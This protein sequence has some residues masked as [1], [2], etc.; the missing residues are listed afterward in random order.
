MIEFNGELSEKC[1][2]YI[3]KRESMISLI[4]VSIATSLFLIPVII[5]IFMV[6]WIF[7][8]GVLVLILIVILSA[9]RP[10]EKYYGKI[11][12]KRITIND[13]DMESCGEEFSCLGLVSQVKKVVDMG[14]WYHIFFNYPYRNPRFVC[15]KDLIKQGTLDEFEKIFEGKIIRKQQ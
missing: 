9:V 7:V 3:L 5:A 10:P 1:K 4:S 15:Q 11:I 14:E 8:L 6:H 2:N 13:D 12:P